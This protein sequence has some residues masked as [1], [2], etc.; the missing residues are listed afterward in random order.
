MISIITPVYNNERYI[1][2]CINN[3]IEQGC[4]G[5]EHLIIDGGS[6][7]STPRIIE[8]YSRKYAHIR[9]ISE[10]DRGQSEAMNKGLSMASGDVVGILNADDFYQPGVLRR[11]SEILKSA[12]EP[13]F[14]VGNCVM[15][16]EEGNPIEVSKPKN[17][18]HIKMLL[19]KI[20]QP[21]PTNPSA[22][23]YHK[24]L[25]ESVGG[26]SLDDHYH[27]DID[28]VFR[29]LKFANV[30]YFDEHWG[31]FR[32]I[33][34]TKTSEN[35]QS[36]LM[37]ERQ[38]RIVRKYQKELPVW[39]KLWVLPIYTIARTGLFVTTLYFIKHPAEFFPRLIN[40][41]RTML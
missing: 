4:S 14:V 15:M 6:T 3:V 22:Y 13:A 31:N 10:K 18:T 2:A 41:V 25:H 11:V 24:S 39:Q 32:F 17:V 33:H 1:E 35:I 30:Y 26:Y 27:M 21:Y 9:W 7:D 19:G 36:G 16:D 5:I 28:M 29:L 38:H 23:F 20:I 34:G 37:E 8:I 40:K 12:T